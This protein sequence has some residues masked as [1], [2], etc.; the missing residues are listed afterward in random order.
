MKLLLSILSLV[1][2]HPHSDKPQ[3]NKNNACFFII[4]LFVINLP[5]KKNIC[6]TIKLMLH[7]VIK[8]IKKD[9]NIL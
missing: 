5:Y 9:F 8:I 1:F 2:E 3:L 4:I 7:L 6:Y